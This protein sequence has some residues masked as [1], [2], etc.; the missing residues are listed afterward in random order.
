MF[1]L[2]RKPTNSDKIVKGKPEFIAQYVFQD[3]QVIKLEIL[4]YREIT[5][6]NS[7]NSLYFK[8]YSLL[9]KDHERTLKELKSRHPNL[10]SDTFNRQL[11]QLYKKFLGEYINLLDMF[12]NNYNHG[13]YSKHI[14]KRKSI[15]EDPERISDEAPDRFL[16][17]ISFNLFS[18][19]VITPNGISYER[20]YLVTHL[21]EKGPFDPLTRQPLKETQLYPNLILKEAVLE[22]INEKNRELTSPA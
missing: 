13:I 16:D 1:N 5:G 14:S 12:K 6:M 17:P 8:M 18:D 22:Y 10:K 9:N 11:V 19:P 20:S 2:F 15:I 3:I 4:K 7:T 21:K